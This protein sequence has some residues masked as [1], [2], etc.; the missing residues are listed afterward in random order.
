MAQTHSLDLERSSSQY[1]SIADGS[2]T[3]L[4]ITGDMTIE[5]WI[6]K[7]S[8][9]AREAIVSKFVDTGTQR[10]YMFSYLDTGGGSLELG[11]SSSGAALTQ[12]TATFAFAT[13]TWYHVAVTYNAAAGTCIFYVNGRNVGTGSSLPTS[14]KNDAAPFVIGAY[15]TTATPAGFFD[16]LIKDV[17]VFNDIRTQAEVVADA[18]TEAV[19]DANLAAEWNF[20][21]N[22]TDNTANNNDLSGSGTPTFS[23][24]R[25]WAGDT[26]ISGSTYIETSLSGY[27]DLDE[28]SGTREDSTAN[29]NDLTDNNT[30]GSA[31]GKINDGADFELSNGDE[32]LSITDAAQT[33]L[34]PTTTF[35]YSGWVKFE[36]LP[37]SNEYFIAGKYGSS[38][39]SWQLEAG[40]QPNGLYLLYTS[41][42]TVSGTAYEEFD[43]ASGIFGSTGVWYHIVVAVDAPNRR[44]S[45]WVNG[46]EIPMTRRGSQNATSIFDGTMPFGMGAKDNGGTVV[47]EHDGMIDEVG[48]WKGRLLHYG[49]VL[50]L[51]NAGNGLPY[52]SSTAYTQD[53]DEVIT[54]VDTISK[55]AQKAVEEV[56]TLVD[57]VAKRA[58]KVLT[59]VVTLVATSNEQL[60]FTRAF[61][62]AVSLSDTVAKQAGKAVEEAITLVDTMSRSIGRTLQDT[63]TLVDTAVTNYLYF[64]TLTEAVTLVDTIAKQ[65]S[66]VLE[67][68][69][70][71]VDSV[72]KRLSAIR[73]TETIT[74]VAT[75]ATLRTYFK[76]FTETVTLV[77]TLAKVGAFARHFTETISLQDRLRGLLNGLNMLL[78]NKYTS[79]AGSYFKKYLDP[80]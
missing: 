78:Q 4:D 50:E 71:L 43:S 24:D 18:H 47:T 10:S 48:F 19:S 8:N 67:E 36:T 30:V 28:A 68:A 40:V 76:A 34:D 55:Q 80:K 25:P 33:G 66:K 7:E 44:V 12:V 16:G 37:A 54:V 31:A 59:D 69:I 6:K 35:S 27:W 21:N 79:K 57:T 23:T 11:V 61:S 73:L 13:G 14:I 45:A 22:Y 49:D 52:I 38:S 3:G 72:A 63:V 32:Y 20:N 58:T 26:Q 70:T 46:I 56:V 65:T 51:Y 60:I 64:R 2:Q 9:N 42:G 41:D 62:E 17:R 39:R 53:L 77:A 15:D 74:L 29:N 75:I 1:A 5:A